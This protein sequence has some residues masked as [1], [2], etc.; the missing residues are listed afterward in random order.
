MATVWPEAED[1]GYDVDESVVQPTRSPFPLLPLP[2]ALPFCRSTVTRITGKNVAGV[3][4][5]EP[6]SSLVTRLRKDGTLPYLIEEG[7][8]GTLPCT[9]CMRWL[10]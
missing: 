9:C 2:V 3:E 6:G 10:Y 7:R 8:E 1:G 5:R 4:H